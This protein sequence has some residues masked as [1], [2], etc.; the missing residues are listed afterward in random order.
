MEHFA[1]KKHHTNLMRQ[2]DQ[3]MH[4]GG[5]LAV[6]TMADFNPKYL[7]AGKMMHAAI[8]KR[9]HEVI[10]INLMNYDCMAL[11]IVMK[12][13]K[14]F[15]QFLDVEKMTTKMNNRMMLSLFYPDN[16]KRTGT[17]MRDLLQEG[18]RM[19][20]DQVRASR[21]GDRQGGRTGVID[22]TNDVLNRA[23]NIAARE[24]NNRLENMSVENTNT[25]MK[26][27][28]QS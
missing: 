15:E 2:M 10:V 16:V 12:Y 23:L 7:F 13:E 20:I 3:N 4:G 28:M 11:E 25:E 24:M 1:G 21:D 6:G 18:W 8:C 14:M 26:Q 22:S 27:M 9:S 17:M 5:D 19:M